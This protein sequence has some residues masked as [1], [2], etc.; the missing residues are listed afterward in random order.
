MKA[1]KITIV[2]M[3]VL[4]LT[5]V[6]AESQMG[7]IEGTAV[8]VTNP[9]S[10]LREAAI[11]TGMCASMW[12]Y[13]AMNGV[14]EGYHW[15]KPGE[16][17]TFAT[18]SNYHFYKTVRDISGIATGWFTYAQVMDSRVSG[19]SKIK[20]VLGAAMIGR[21][22]FEMSYRLQRYKTIFEYSQSRNE[23]ALVY[24]TIKNGAV[25]DAY[26]GT[27]PVSGPLVDAA[28]FVLGAMLLR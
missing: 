1:V 21:N 20:R 23:H 13:Q 25:V 10:W 24:F 14:S 19:W 27:G 8:K 26:I 2:M 22:A 4:I 28:F 6:T 11:T 3:L 7:E 12:T 15:G 5:T 9:N 17:Y 18:D 16:S